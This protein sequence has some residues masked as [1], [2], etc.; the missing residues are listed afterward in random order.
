MITRE[1][2][3]VI[4]QWGNYIFSFNGKAA[5]AENREKLKKILKKILLT[6]EFKWIPDKVTKII[7]VKFALGSFQ[8]QT[9][10]EKF[11]VTMDEET[12]RKLKEFRDEETESMKN[13]YKI[14]DESSYERNGS[15]MMYE[16]YTNAE[17]HE[18]NHESAKAKPNEI[19]Q[20]EKKEEPILKIEPSASPNE[21]KEEDEEEFTGESVFMDLLGKGEF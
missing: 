4:K 3:E 10:N 18:E 11:L 13:L 12:R 7:H 8:I 15:T 2:Y 16:D 1:R 9:V 19:P 14:A 6:K 5:N 17:Y 21:T 20:Q